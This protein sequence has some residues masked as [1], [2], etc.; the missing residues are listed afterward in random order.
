MTVPRTFF[1]RPTIKTLGIAGFCLMLGLAL[2][3]GLQTAE[4][5]E[6]QGQWYRGW[7]GA[8]VKATTVKHESMERQVFGFTAKEVIEP[9]AKK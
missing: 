7:C 6:G 8:R 1:E 9:A 4:A 3:N 2:G 5:L